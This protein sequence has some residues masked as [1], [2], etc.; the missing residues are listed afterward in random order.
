MNTYSTMTEIALWIYIAGI[1]AY[2][3]IWFRKLSFLKSFPVIFMIAGGAI[4]IVFLAIRWQEGGRPPFKTLYES[5]ILLA[6]CIA[7][8]YI[9]IELIYKIRI[10]GIL[11]SAGCALTMGYAYSIMDKEIIKI[12]PALQSGWFIPHVVV[13]FFGYAAVFI[14]FIAVIIYLFHPYPIKHKREE[15]IGIRVIDIEQFSA[16]TMRF[17][18]ALLTA[19]L[20]MGAFWAKDA[21]G[22]YWVWDP[23]ET[24]SLITW[25][26]FAMIIHLRYL[27][28]WRGRRYA[29][30][31]II[32]FGAVM[33]TYLGMNLLPSAESSL[34]IYQ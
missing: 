15:L 3:L 28:N 9:I 23:K 2:G 24:W 7:T 26:I 29:V 25:L 21:W 22:D 11:A 19:G 20:L 18:F 10:L 1:A 32:G 14:T 16:E 27:K 13:Y 5:L 4:N 8:I 30:I 17:G 31:V 12:P 33:F 6:G 34:H